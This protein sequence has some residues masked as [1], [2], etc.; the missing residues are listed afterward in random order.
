L[1]MEEKIDESQLPSWKKELQD[2]ACEARSN[3]KSKKN[4]SLTA[5]QQNIE[6]HY[7]A[8]R[9]AEQKQKKYPGQ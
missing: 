8:L 7:A 4:Q 6:G 2:F 3:S 5:E 1:L 9:N